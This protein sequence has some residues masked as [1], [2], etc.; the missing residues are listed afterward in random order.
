MEDL[1][2][3]AEEDAVSRSFPIAG[4]GTGGVRATGS[5][6]H[7]GAIWALAGA[8]WAGCWWEGTSSGLGC[9]PGAHMPTGRVYQRRGT[10]PLG[11]QSQRV[12][13]GGEQRWAM[14]GTMVVGREEW[15]ARRESTRR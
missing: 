11:A 12:R 8:T 9:S 14:A 4:E 2:L 7:T 13:R 6:A 5:R 15:S 1:E 3:I 10:V